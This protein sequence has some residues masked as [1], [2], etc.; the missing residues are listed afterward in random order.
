MERSIREIADLLGKPPK[1]IHTYISRGKLIKNYENKIDDE[2]EVNK[3]FIERFN[4][5]EGPQVQPKS[6]P[7]RKTRAKNKPEPQEQP[8]LEIEYKNEESEEEKTP[9]KESIKQ[10]EPMSASA[11][12]Q[13]DFAIKKLNAKKTQTQIEELEIKRDRISGKL[14]PKDQILLTTEMH[15]N[16]LTTQFNNAFD[17]V[18]EFIYISKYI[19]RKDQIKI[20]KE[21]QHIVNDCID[22]A[23]EQTQL[24]IERIS[25]EQATKTNYNV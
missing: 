10:T 5:P 15:F 3:Y 12:M 13:L 8:E 6:K 4:T 21:K 14:L 20:K 25:S 1:N 18:L 19:K 17:E 23:R 7:K 11:M 16:N 22:K 24:D 2:N 9:I